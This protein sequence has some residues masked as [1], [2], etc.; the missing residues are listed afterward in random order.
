MN[1]AIKF[2]GDLISGLM[3]AFIVVL[4]CISVAAVWKFID[5]KDVLYKSVFSFSIL[6]IAYV[7]I[8]VAI[9]YWEVRH[10]TNMMDGS[11]TM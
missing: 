5:V 10:D 7:V 9:H 11:N 4:T 1:Q 3:I 2:F 6:A 8:I